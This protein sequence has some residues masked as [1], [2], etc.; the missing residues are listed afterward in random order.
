MLPNGSFLP[1]RDIAVAR[2]A[3]SELKKQT[4]DRVGPLMDALQFRDGAMKRDASRIRELAR[5]VGA[6]QN[7]AGRN[8]H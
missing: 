5:L 1:Y 7:E 4:P 6:L 2:E 8:P 3:P